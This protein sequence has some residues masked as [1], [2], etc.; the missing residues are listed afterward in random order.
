MPAVNPEILTW[1]RET[2]GLSLERA[3]DAIQLS[4][5]R[6]LS[7]AERLEALENPKA[8]HRVLFSAAWLKNI[9]AR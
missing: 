3:A 5:A 7:G 6:G 4:A 8:N 1:A 2:A 9:A